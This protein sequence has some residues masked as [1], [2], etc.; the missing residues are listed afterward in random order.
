MKNHKH[1][2]YLYYCRCSSVDCLKA[3]N[4]WRQAFFSSDIG[5]GVSPSVHPYKHSN[6]GKRE[7]KAG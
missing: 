2:F 1:F 4:E 3:I 5:E 7:G 6:Y